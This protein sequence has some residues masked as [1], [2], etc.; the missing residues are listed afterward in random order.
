MKRHSQSG[1]SPCPKQ[2]FCDSSEE[3]EDDIPH[4]FS[5]YSTSS[6]PVFN[7]SQRS[8][9]SQSQPWPNMELP[10]SDVSEKDTGSI[11]G[12]SSK[13]EV[14]AKLDFIISPPA[15]GLLFDSEIIWFFATKRKNLLRCTWRKQNCGTALL[16]KT[17]V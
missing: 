1:S 8:S 9:S 2:L 11:L 15:F 12:K 3:S 5:Q 16:M 17:I 4:F 7:F 13:I 10:F 14:T 6:N